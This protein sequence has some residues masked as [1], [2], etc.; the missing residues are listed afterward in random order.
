MPPTRNKDGSVLTGLA[1]YRIYY[2][3][4]PELGSTVTV[5][6]AGLTRYVMSGLLRATWYFALTAYD[7]NGRESDRTEV[8]SIAVTQ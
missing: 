2:G 8:A 1:G 3:S 5:S 4:T 7:K 6:N